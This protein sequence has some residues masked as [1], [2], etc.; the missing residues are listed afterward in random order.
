MS[1]YIHPTTIIEDNVE[2]WE[3]NFI[4]PFSHIF[5]GTIIGNNN[6]FEGYC[7][8]GSPPEFV[9]YMNNE[10]PSKGVRIWDNNIFR[11]YVAITAGSEAS[12]VIA[13]NN[14][15]LTGTY[16]AHDVIFE[17]NITCSAWVKIAGFVYVMEWVNFWMGAICHQS[18]VIGAYSMLWMGTI[19]TKKSAILPWKI[20]IWSPATFL[21]ENTIGLE[22]GSISEQDLKMLE[23]RYLMFKNK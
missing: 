14:I 17:N 10:K 16:I 1:N 23:E 8:V 7:S 3:N 12:T 21:R 4:G 22:R 11:E 5:S 6:R 15:L 19:V 13:N 18:T 9:G 2:I 20:Y